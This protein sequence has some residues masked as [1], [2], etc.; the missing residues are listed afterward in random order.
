[1]PL[2]SKRLTVTVPGELVPLIHERMAEEHISSESK[3]C[4]SLILFD[5]MTR[6]PHKITAQ[7]VN[8]PEDLFYKVVDEIVREFPEARKRMGDWL[9]HRIEEIV[10]T[11][12]RHA[13]KE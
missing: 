7:V 12:S 5:L 8:E 9:R 11:D 3:Y 4:L 13:P 6:A 2:K 10:A 1:M